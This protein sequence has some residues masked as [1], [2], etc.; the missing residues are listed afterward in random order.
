MG[1]KEGSGRWVG[2]DKIPKR[3]EKE[4]NEK[5]SNVGMWRMDEIERDFFSF[6][7]NKQNKKQ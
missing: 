4:Q 7:P 5:G 6:I 3:D 2:W 1:R